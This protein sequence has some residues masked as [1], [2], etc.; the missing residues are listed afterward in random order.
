MRSKSVFAPIATTLSPPSLLPLC[1]RPV[2]FPLLLKSGKG[3]QGRPGEACALPTTGL[4]HFMGVSR[5]RTAGRVLLPPPPPRGS[6]Q[7]PSSK[8]RERRCQ[9]GASSGG[10]G[11]RG[12][13]SRQGQRVCRCSWELCSLSQVRNVQ[14]TRNVFRTMVRKHFVISGSGGLSC[15]ALHQVKPQSSSCKMGDPESRSCG[16]V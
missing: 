4:N 3:G 11:R 5:G 13:P 12:A 16:L 14:V 15:A 7:P 10:S 2:S 1:L 8:Q 9:D 6:G